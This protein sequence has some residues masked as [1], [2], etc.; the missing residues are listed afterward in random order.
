MQN[1]NIKK[2][3]LSMIKRGDYQYPPKEGFIL[4]HFLTVADVK[5]SAEFYL[6]ILGGNA[7]REGEPT[8]IQIANSWLI[9]NVGGGPT[10]DKPTVTLRTPQNP[11]EVS[12]FI[13]QVVC[14]PHPDQSVLLYHAY[15]LPT[16]EAGFMNRFE[17]IFPRSHSVVLKG[18]GHFTPEEPPDEISSAIMSWWQSLR[19]IKLLAS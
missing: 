11:N 10:D 15:L 2:E 7:V 19:E 8:I 12:S 17:R 3:D 9:L 5:R 4:T 1:T 18:A 13:V 6:R 14:L 16:F